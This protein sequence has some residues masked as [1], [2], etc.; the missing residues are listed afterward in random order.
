[1]YTIQSF[2]LTLESRTAA[3]R[4]IKEFVEKN[5]YVI[6][7]DM[8]CNQIFVDNEKYLSR[9]FPIGKLHYEYWIPIE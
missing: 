6:N 2:N 3:I 4:T 7:G 5:K 9:Q 1:I 8:V